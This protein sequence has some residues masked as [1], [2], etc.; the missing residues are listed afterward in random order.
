MKHLSEMPFVFPTEQRVLTQ[1][2]YDSL[3]YVQIG[4]IPK[5][6]FQTRSLSKTIFPAYRAASKEEYLIDYGTLLVKIGATLAT[7]GI[8]TAGKTALG[9]TISKFN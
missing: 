8:L 2:E 7:G 4:N 9:F 3:G 1:D 5:T 6:N